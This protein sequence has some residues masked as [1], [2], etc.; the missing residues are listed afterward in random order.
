MTPYSEKKTIEMT[1]DYS[2]ETM[3]A[4]QEVVSFSQVLQKSCQRRILSPVTVFFRKERGIKMSDEGNKK[5][6]SP[7]ERGCPLLPLLFSIVLE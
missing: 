7:A 5:E 2:L 1:A 4:I 3:E 6:L